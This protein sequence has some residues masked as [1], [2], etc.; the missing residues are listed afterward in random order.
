[1]NEII[2][3]NQTESNCRIFCVGCENFFEE[4]RDLSNTH[5]KDKKEVQKD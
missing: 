1:M 4:E 2:V 5:I 3:L